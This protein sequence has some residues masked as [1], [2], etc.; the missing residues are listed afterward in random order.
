MR[1]IILTLL[2][3]LTFATPVFCAEFLPKYRNSFQNYGIGI[4]FGEGKIT[5]YEEP[6]TTSKVLATVDWN[7]DYAFINN[8]QTKP[9]NVFIVFLP[10]NALAGFV[11]VDEEGA[12][13]TKI[14]YD[15]QKQLTG[16]I[17]N[18]PE[19]KPF[20]WRQLFY[21]YGRSKGLYFFS[22]TPKDEK[23]LK[24]APEDTS[25][26]SYNFIYPKYI[27]LQLIKGNWALLKVV[28]YDDEQKVG[29]FQWRN[30][31]GTLNMF[32]QFKEKY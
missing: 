24:M 5:V 30:P 20:Y 7:K 31:D 11:A 6:S 29:W 22:D 13:F 10:D 26:I 25:E 19:N 23:S 21:K 16:W 27:R 12:E 8:V 3:M 18:T 9:Q 17:K 14:V 1:R 4:Y 28:D 2:A 32:P 15:A